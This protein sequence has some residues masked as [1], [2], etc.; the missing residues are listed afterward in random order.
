MLREVHDALVGGVL[1]VPHDDALVGV[2]LLVPPHHHP[3]VP[4]LG[5]SVGP[6]VGWGGYGMVWYGMGWYGMVWYGVLTLL[7]CSS[8]PPCWRMMRSPCSPPPSPR[9]TINPPCN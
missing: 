3:L 4:V 5:A 1:A 6:T 8:T 2:A 9:P 7:Y